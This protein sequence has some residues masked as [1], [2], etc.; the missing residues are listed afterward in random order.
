MGKSF[1]GSQLVTR[2]VGECPE[3]TLHLGTARDV[4]C[5]LDTGA[6]VS[7][8]TETFFREHLSHEMLIDVSRFINIKGAQGLDI[9]YCGY[10]ELIFGVLGRDFNNMGFL[11]VKDPPD[12]SVGMRKRLV[13]GVIGSN[14]LR[15]MKRALEAEVHGNFQDAL[16]G[17][18]G[19]AWA[20]VLALYEEISVEPK[21]EPSGRARVT[22]DGTILLQKRCTQIIEVSVRAARKGEVRT[23]LIYETRGE[24]LLPGVHVAP[25]LLQITDTGIVALCVTNFSTHDVYLKPKTPLGELHEV[26]QVEHETGGVMSPLIEEHHVRV[27]VPGKVEDILGKMEVGELS[28]EQHTELCKLIEEYRDVFSRDDDDIGLCNDIPHRIYTKDDVPVKMPHRRVPPHHW[29]EVRDYLQQCLDKGIIR[30]SSSPYAAPIVLVRKKDGKLRLCVD[31]RALNAKTHK[32]AYP[33]PRIEE[34]LEALRG[35][36]FFCSLDLAHGFHQIPVADEDIP[37]TAFRVGTGGLYEFVRMPFGLCNAPATCMRLIVKGFGDQNFR[38]I[39]TYLDDILVFGRTFEETLGRLEMVLGRLRMM[40]LKIKVEKCHLFKKKLKYLGHMVEEGG[41]SPDPEKVRAVKEW[42]VPRTETELRSFLGLAG[43]YRRFVPHFATIAAPLHALIGGTAKSKKQKAKSSKVKPNGPSIAELWDENCD[44][45]FQILKDHLTSAPLLGHPDFTEPFIVETDASLQGLGAV[46]SQKQEGRTV[47][48]AYASRGLRPH[49]KNMENYSSMKL[50][51]LALYWAVTDKFRDILIGA[52]FTVFTDNNPLS[53]LQTTVKLGATEMRWQAELAQFKFNIVYRS[54]RE[55][56]N[57]DALSRKVDHGTESNRLEQIQV[58][59]MLEQSTLREP[60]PLPRQLQVRVEEVSNVSFPGPD[61]PH[62]VGTLPTIPRQEL[63]QLQRADAIVGR[64]IALN[65]QDGRLP[66]RKLM[67]EQKQV[68][69]LV[70][71][72]DRLTF[73]DGVLYGQ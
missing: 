2:A 68:R 57:A 52:E 33:L 32:D 49:E 59:T 69:K 12:S 39:L 28:P 48:L 30:E 13:P 71:Q 27:G 65:L 41:I 23:A 58:D 60:S 24:H 43:Y 47:V 42:P 6:Q 64:A 53:Y 46:L 15:D 62:T 63:A 10:V 16:K 40:N 11:V 4:R 36:R 19:H 14:V 22:G 18:D 67:K 5:L 44:N 7:T 37:K 3:A 8:L 38:T 35:A 54:G 50:E 73:I 21:T 17:C 26:D 51:L 56:L 9:P 45:A 20:S 61:Q 55:N 70:R 25:S 34:A 66:L 1:D 31:Y 72:K 29:Q